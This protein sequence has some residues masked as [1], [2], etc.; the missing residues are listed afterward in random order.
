MINSGTSQTSANTDA[1]NIA[2]ED[3]RSFEMKKISAF[4]ISFITALSAMP[5]EVSANDNYR[6]YSQNSFDKEIIA[7]VAQGETDLNGNGKFDIDDCY[8]LFAHTD[9]YIVDDATKERIE[10]YADYDHDGSVTWYGDALLMLKYYLMTKPLDTSIF[11][12]DIRLLRRFRK[13]MNKR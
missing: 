4:A 13:S 6:L 5:M 7:Q 8:K 9:G 2:P 11:N 1:S 12:M 3:E 10:R